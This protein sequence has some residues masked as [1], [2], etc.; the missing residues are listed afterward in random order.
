M[1]GVLW[2]ALGRNLNG[3]NRFDPGTGEFRVFTTRN[4]LPNNVIYGVLCDAAGNLWASSNRGLT[5]LNP[6]TGE[7]LNIAKLT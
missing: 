7:K 6:I 1:P 2:S 3:L 5:R 4:G